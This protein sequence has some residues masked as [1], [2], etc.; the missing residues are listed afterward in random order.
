[1]EAQTAG[2]D[3]VEYLKSIGVSI[4]EWNTKSIGTKMILVKKFEEMKWNLP[5]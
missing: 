4:I 1:M 3:W 2:L 5:N